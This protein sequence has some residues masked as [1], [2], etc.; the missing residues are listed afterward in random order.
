M[1]KTTHYQLNQWAPEDRILRTDF[2]ADNAKLDQALRQGAEDLAAART[3]AEEALAQ[4]R[5][6]R[7]AGVSAASQAAAEARQAALGAV[8]SEQSAREGQ[9]AAIRQ[10]LSAAVAGAKSEASAAV[11]AE[12]TA[13]TDQDAAIRR[14]FAAADAAAAAAVPL[15]K[16]REITTS[17]AAAQVDLDLG[18]IAL[19]SYWELIIVPRLSA[20]SNYIY[21][22]INGLSERVYVGDGITDYISMTYP[23]NSGAY[24]VCRL[25]AYGGSVA[26]RTHLDGYARNVGLT[27]M[28]AK[29]VSTSFL[30]PAGL[31]TVNFYTNDGTPIAAGGKF[32]IYGIRL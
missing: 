13:R 20:S 28:M 4:E 21:L 15:V 11:T 6:E 27:T 12:R 5:Q 2:N 32:T 19:G 7:A 29:A 25:Y 3:A 16:L 22:R 23:F 24:T 14:D 17:A 31:R 8:A 18:G 26:C 10:E 30:T 9:D 1:D